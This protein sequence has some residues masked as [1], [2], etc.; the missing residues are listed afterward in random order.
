MS[1]LWTET[2]GNTY[3]TQG[4]AFTIHSICNTMVLT[5]QRKQIQTTSW[6]QQHTSWCEAA[7]GIECRYHEGSQ[8]CHNF[9]I[10]VKYKNGINFNSAHGHFCIF[11][12]R[13]LNNSLMSVAAHYRCTPAFIRWPLAWIV[14]S[15]TRSLYFLAKCSWGV[16][17]RRCLLELMCRASA[18]IP[19]QITRVSGPLSYDIS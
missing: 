9:Y 2:H 12:R 16:I 3:I 13:S 17:I 1:I 18:C 5:T 14:V 7:L 19:W 15:P 6:T 8:Q 4:D 10:P 11:A